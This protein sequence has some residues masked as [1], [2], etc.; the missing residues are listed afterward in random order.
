MIPVYQIYQTETSINV[1]LKLIIFPLSDY[2]TPSQGMAKGNL[3]TTG[4]SPPPFLGGPCQYILYH[5]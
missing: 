1:I 2:K 4:I 3:S 5:L